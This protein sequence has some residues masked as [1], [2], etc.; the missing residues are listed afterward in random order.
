MPKLRVAPAVAA[1]VTDRAW[2]VEEIV[3]FLEEQ[4]RE[5]HAQTYANKGTVGAYGIKALFP[6]KLV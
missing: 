1:N 2:D 3:S 6:K 4:E 5:D